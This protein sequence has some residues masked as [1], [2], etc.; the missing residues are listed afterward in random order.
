MQISSHGEASVPVYLLLITSRWCQS[1]LSTC[2][3]ICV[4]GAHLLWF[5]DSLA[6]VGHS[7]VRHYMRGELRTLSHSS[8]FENY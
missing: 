1:F 7:G 4:E 2:L 3:F 8:S 6:K 5:H